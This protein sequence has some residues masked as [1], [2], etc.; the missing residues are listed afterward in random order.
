MTGII[1]ETWFM[2]HNEGSPTHSNPSGLNGHYRKMV[3]DLEFTYITFQKGSWAIVVLAERAGHGDSQSMGYG[4]KR[5]HVS[6][7]DM[8][9]HCKKMELWATANLNLQK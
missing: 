1:G 7:T 9:M 6:K 3:I 8:W 5:V 2:N 4:T